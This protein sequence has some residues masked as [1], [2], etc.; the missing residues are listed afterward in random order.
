MEGFKSVDAHFFECIKINAPLFHNV[1]V[2]SNSLQANSGRYSM[3]AFLH[4]VPMTENEKN[5]LACGGRNS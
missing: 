4:E 2:R 3:S 5:R 1:I